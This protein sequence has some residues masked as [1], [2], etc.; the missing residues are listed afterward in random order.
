[1]SFH[2]HKT[3]GFRTAT[4]ESIGYTS[5]QIIKFQ[6]AGVREC[7]MAGHQLNNTARAHF[8]ALRGLRRPSGF[9]R[10]GIG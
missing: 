1:M 2:W 10:T 6:M 5:S 7:V 9:P 4:L 3:S 8:E